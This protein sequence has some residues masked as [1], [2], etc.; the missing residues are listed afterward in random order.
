[1]RCGD[2]PKVDYKEITP[3]DPKPSIYFNVRYPPFDDSTPQAVWL[4]DHVS[5]VFQ[6]TG[7]FSDFSLARHSGDCHLNLL[8]V[9]EDIRPEKSLSA[10][11]A[12]LTLGFVP[13]SYKSEATLTAE[14]RRQGATLRTYTY[15][16][17]T[18]IFCWTII[19]WV[20]VNLQTKAIADEVI[21]DMLLSLLK[22]LA[23]DRVLDAS[24]AHDSR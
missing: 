24:A 19:G 6:K 14:V 17:H 20:G 10:M 15:S 2:L 12:G 23:R 16:E 1:R 13:L 9:E 22:D 21:D 4:R 3:P 8:Y 11:G 18:E 7:F 5:Q